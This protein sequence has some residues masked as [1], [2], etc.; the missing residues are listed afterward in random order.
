MTPGQER[1]R[2]LLAAVLAS[3][4]EN[5]TYRDVLANGIE[6]GVSTPWLGSMW[7]LFH[8]ACL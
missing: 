4:L 8:E 5:E 1:S 7:R 6:N 2:L 3:Q